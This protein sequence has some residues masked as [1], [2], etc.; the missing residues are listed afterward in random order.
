MLR[1]VVGLMPVEQHIAL[2]PENERGNMDTR[3]FGAKIAPH[4]FLCGLPQEGRGE[5]SKHQCEKNTWMRK[6]KALAHPGK[7]YFLTKSTS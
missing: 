4:H 6:S 2:A 1:E 7:T 5:A 3:Q